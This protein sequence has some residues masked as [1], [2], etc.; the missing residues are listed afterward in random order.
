[1]KNRIYF[2]IALLWSSIVLFAQAPNISYPAGIYTF[3]IGTAITPLNPTNTGGAVPATIYGQ[4]ST[5]AGSG[6]V[7]STDGIGTAASFN[8][9]YDVAVDATGNLY[10]ADY[11][12]N[13]IR[14][15]TPTGVVITFAGSGIVGSNEGTGTAAS[16][17]KPS[18]VAIDATGNIYVADT[19]NNK[20]RKITPGGKV[21][22]FAGTGTVGSN[23]GVFPS[24]KNPSG[25]VVD[26]TGNVYVADFG[27]NKIRKITSSGVVSTLAGIGIVGSN[28]GAN[29]AAS[30]NSPSG[31]EIDAA[32]NVYVADYR[33]FTIRKITKGGNVTTLAGSVGGIGWTGGSIDGTGSAATFSYPFGVTIDA[34]GNLYVADVSLNRIR[35]VSP[36]GVVSTLAGN[37]T[38]SWVDG[39]GVAASFKNPFGVAIDAKGVIYVADTYNH[40]I[41]KIITTG[42]TINPTLVAGLS[43]D[44]ATGVISGTPTISSS[45]TSYT[46]TA[47]NTNGSSS[48][49]VVIAT[50][51]SLGITTFNK[52]KLKLYPNPVNT[53][54]HIQ[55]PNNSSIDKVSIVDLTGKKV[56]EQKNTS[57]IDVARLEKG[58]YI[59]EAFSGEGKFSSKFMKE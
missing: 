40:R 39:I 41:R 3:G 28:D 22:T 19:N 31:V 52:Q 7:G 12:N 47:Y 56:L 15:I 4:V 2:L 42:Y 44:N 38:N 10:V 35:K 21:I 45:A 46:V 57:Q 48:T 24:F 37:S 20:I 54:L 59:I 51:T 6:I 43:F 16:F 9:P 5:F 27:N 30:F 55:T 13:K 11:M 1:M 29:T 18:G 23:D 36:A 49:K 26:A 58:M 50:N 17:N 14:K 8:N 34:S 33:N 25:L 32:G 53:L